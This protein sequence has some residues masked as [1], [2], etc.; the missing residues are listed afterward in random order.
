MRFFI[1]LLL[2]FPWFYHRNPIQKPLGDHRSS[3]IARGQM[4]NLT[5]DKTG[6]V[7][8]VYGLGDSIMYTESVDHGT[9]FST[10]L[11]VAI[12]PNLFATAMRGPQVVDTD[13]GV[14]IL[15]ANK[16]G[17]IYSYHKTGPD[18]WEKP[19]RVNDVDAVAKEGLMALS[20]D[21][22]TMF[23]VWLDLRANKRNK[24]VGA[25]SDDGGKTWSANR[26]IYASPDSSVCE[27]CKPSVVVKDHHIYVMFRNW[28]KGSRDLY[29][30]RSNDDGQHFD[31][32]EKL[33]NGTW[34]LRGCPMDGGG[35]TVDAGNNPQTIWRR[36]NKIFSCPPGKQE[37]E[38]GEGRD[39]TITFVKGVNFFAWNES[40]EI[41][42]LL[43]HSDKKVLGKGSLPIL[44]AI[45]DK[46]IICV[47]ENEGQVCKVVLDI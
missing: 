34:P 5:V 39:G 10:P 38:I 29:L 30:T 26:L 16:A 13:H 45:N 36:Q 7:F 3:V 19:V 6:N 20:G 25:K 33:G 28:L 17:N 8:L 14:T 18:Q 11:L 42:C 12:L 21:G 24:I 47:W 43:S 41:V 46:E 44:K 1:S 23:A 4:P 9:S 15:A 31:N 27:C 37:V 32:A 22:A 40:G 2:L 35:L